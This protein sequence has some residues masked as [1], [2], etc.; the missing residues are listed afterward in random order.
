MIDDRLLRMEAETSWTNYP[1]S[2]ITYV[3]EAESYREQSD[4]E[5]K[6][7]TFSMD[8]LLPDDLLERIL[9]FLPIASIFRAGTVCK[10]WNE[11][12]SSRRFLCNFSNNSVSQRP[13]YFMFTTTDDPSGY[14]YDPI[15]RKWYSFDLP[16]IETS[17]WFVASSCGLVCFMD[18]DC[19]NKI[20]VSNPITKQWRT[21]I[22][23]PGH[24]STDYT[25]MSTSVNRANQAVNRA[26]RSYSVSIVKSKQ[27][28]GNFFQWDLSIHLYSSETMTW[29][30]L[31]NDVLSGWRGGNESVICNN[32]LYFM[33]Y[34]TGGSDHRHG[35]IASNLSSIG[36]PSSG[37]LMRS[38]IPMPCS[39]TCG[40]LMNL[41]ER[42]VIVGGI[43]KHDRPEVI[44]GIGIWVLKG[45]EWVEMAKM[46]QRFF[47]GFGEFDEVFASSG[48]DD[49]VY[50]Q[51]YGSP[52]LLTFD[53]NL[54][55]WRWSQ[56]CPVTKKFP[57]QLFT[58]F[59]F[60]PRLE[61]AP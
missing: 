44:K 13:W 3:P 50:I 20:Y 47:Q 10:R 22:E 36:S 1:Y 35:L 11:I 51:S 18:N 45:K 57:L 19:R 48:T 27:V 6:V 28:P 34:S 52:A 29:T 14:A 46:P 4:D 16:C 30:T 5:A 26:N 60:E 38:F 12:V 7:E 40:R 58:G 31:V 61:I 9:S 59:C 33:I 24:K 32:V 56:K 54:K 42:L 23:P 17:N 55:Y 37:I 2:Y 49:L 41:R 25:A 15:I 8:S 39:L 21:L 43:G 53:M